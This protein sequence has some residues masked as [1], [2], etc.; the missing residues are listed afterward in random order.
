VPSRVRFTALAAVL[1]PLACLGIAFDSRNPL[2]HTYTDPII[3]EFL[4]GALIGKFW[5]AGRL[6]SP[7]VGLA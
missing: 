4:L 1:V 7:M 5:L 6:P 2:L 3:L